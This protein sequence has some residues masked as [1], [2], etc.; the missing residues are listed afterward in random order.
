VALWTRASRGRR[1]GRYRGEIA[2]RAADCF[3]AN[4]MPG[5]LSPWARGISYGARIID[6]GRRGDGAASSRKP[7]RQRDDRR[8]VTRLTVTAMLERVQ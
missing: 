3:T 5:K 1:R 4:P 8:T 7:I 6:V 2:G